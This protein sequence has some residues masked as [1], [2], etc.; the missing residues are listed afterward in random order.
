MTRGTRSPGRRNRGRRWRRLHELARDFADGL[1]VGNFK[2]KVHKR[3]VAKLFARS[4]LVLDAES[5]GEVARELM[6]P[7]P[8]PPSVPP[9]G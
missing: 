4:D 8:A 7:S 6:Q 3:G 1:G 9:P 5:I 2:M